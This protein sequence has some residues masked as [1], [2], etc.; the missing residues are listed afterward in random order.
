MLKN[1]NSRI[2]VSFPYRL[3]FLIWKNLCFILPC[4]GHQQFAW[5]REFL[6]H[7]TLSLKI[8]MIFMFFTNLPSV[9]YLF[10]IWRPPSSSLTAVL[11]TVSPNIY[12]ILY[13]NNSTTA[14]VW[15]LQILITFSSIG[16]ILGIT[17]EIFPRSI[18]LIWVLLL[19]LLNFVNGFMLG[20]SISSIYI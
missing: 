17:S 1:I 6:L 11:H 20:L 14:C 7:L 15:R 8:L 4:M 5:K 18:S 19:L 13:V 3:N 12:R 9:P 10:V 2:S 16:T